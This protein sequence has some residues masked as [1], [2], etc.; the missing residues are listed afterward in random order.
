MP[1]EPGSCRA[2]PPAVAAAEERVRDHLA[3]GHWRA[4]RDEAKPLV[5]QDRGRFLPLLLKANIGLANEMLRKGQVA[6]ARQVM[7]YLATMAPAD[8]LRALE[9]ELGGSAPA[10]VGDLAEALAGL[11]GPE[12]GR[13][14]TSA[15]RWAD[16][17]ILAFQPLSAEDP[18]RRRIADEARAIQEALLALSLE[19][20]DRAAELLRAVPHRSAFRHWSMLL[21]GVMAFHA[22]DD[23]RALRCFAGL[24]SDSVPGRASQGYRWLIDTRRGRGRPVVPAEPVLEQACRLT[25]HPGGG[26]ALLEAE[27]LWKAGHHPEAYHALCRAIP[28]FPT[29]GSDWVGALSEFSFRAPFTLAEDEREQYLSALEDQW[30]RRGY[31]NGVEELEAARLIAL[32][33]QDGFDPTDLRAVWEEYLEVH[34]RQHGRNPRLDSIAYGWL[35]E[36]LARVQ[37]PAFGFIPQ[38]HLLDPEGAVECLRKSIELDPGNL[39][40]HLKLSELYG[41]LHRKRDRNRLLDFMTARFPEE[42]AVLLDAG[43]Q[44]LERKSHTKAIEYFERAR[45]QDRLDPAI[46]TLIVTA[47]RSL[48]RHYYEKRRLAKGRETLEALEELLT[49]RPD[50]LHCSRWTHRLRQGLF[51]LAY[52]D[53]ARST[54]LLEAAR[55]GSPFPAAFCL[56]AHLAYRVYTDEAECY[57]PFRRELEGALRES[58]RA[59]HA[60]LLLETIRYWRMAANPPGVA[61]EE[62]LLRRYLKAALRQPFT[63]TE[64]S[65][66]LDL[67]GADPTFS[68]VLR[69]FLKPTLGQDPKDPL[70]RFFNLLFRTSG[71]EPTSRDRSELTSILHE[72]ERRH[73]GRTAQ[74]V[75]RLL[76]RL[77]QPV[78]PPPIPSFGDEDWDFGVPND[79]GE[80]DEFESLPR[81][82]PA[83][84]ENDIARFL[85]DLG[86]LSE[87]E[88]RQLRR[89]LPK[90]IP[91]ALI[92]V[93][94]EAAKRG[95]RLPIQPLP[96]P[97]SRRPPRGGGGPPSPDQLDLF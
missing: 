93:F 26:R 1:P 65:Q 69:P 2:L 33:E 20:W 68:S 3:H 31:R 46:P 56:F 10:P 61:G 78:F 37:P 55:Q 53:A 86:G 73:D 44:C 22:A 72:A 43:R 97:Q 17:L 94:I 70:F 47:R 88:L 54:A 34:R 52:G 42:K 5:K 9:L 82:P 80:D 41:R 39:G 32:D 18:E 77:D 12:T 83:D 45:Q 64:V 75:R 57:S 63:R 30:A 28:S 85:Q 25:G 74:I 15:V 11:A 7:A 19:Q 8:E 92:D 66:L 50:D 29:A 48:A 71:R 35:G 58:P 27:R 62:A 40:A 49:D 23:E 95:R 13:N 90:G 87:A 67:K 38:E 24:P 89:S 91:P 21:K 84:F 4:A 16:R 96:P 36:Q 76:Q 6:E 60:V 51:E 59:A 81:E 14:E 79:P